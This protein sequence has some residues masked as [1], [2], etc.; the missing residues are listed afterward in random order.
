[1][2][3]VKKTEENQTCNKRKKTIWCQKQIIIAQGFSEKICWQ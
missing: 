2:G 1:M 3:N